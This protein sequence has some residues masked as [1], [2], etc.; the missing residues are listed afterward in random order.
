LGR[1]NLGQFLIDDNVS[2]NSLSQRTV[3]DHSFEYAKV[4][5]PQDNER[6]SNLDETKSLDSTPP[7]ISAPRKKTW[8]Q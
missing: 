7:T 2:A 4:Y 8:K 5:A 6:I 3:P 1:S